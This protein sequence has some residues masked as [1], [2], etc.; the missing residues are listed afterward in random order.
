LALLPSVLGDVVVAQ[1]QASGPVDEVRRI[2]RVRKADGRTAI[3]LYDQYRP[4]LLGVEAPEAV[5]V[6]NSGQFNSGD[7]LL[8]SAPGRRRGRRYSDHAPGA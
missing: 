1:E 8:N 2:G 5:W 6:R 4:G 3:E 7:S